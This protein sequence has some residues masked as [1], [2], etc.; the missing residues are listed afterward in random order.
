MPFVDCKSQYDFAVIII[1]SHLLRSHST[2][3]WVV[4][5]FIDFIDNYMLYKITTKSYSNPP[6]P[7]T[8]NT[9]Q[10]HLHKQ[11]L[12]PEYTNHPRDNLANPSP[13]SLPPGKEKQI[14]EGCRLKREW[15]QGNLHTMIS[16]GVPFQTAAKV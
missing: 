10:C 8:Q 4:I 3:F 2:F 6:T 1:A 15:K 13:C 7:S 12:D 5:N 11:C 16:F 14:H 9:N